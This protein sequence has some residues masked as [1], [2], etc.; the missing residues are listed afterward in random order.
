MSNKK[1]TI[2]AP[3][4]SIGQ[5]RLATWRD[6][7]RESVSLASCKKGSKGKHEKVEIVKDFLKDIKTIEQYFVYPGKIR[8][9]KLCNAVNKEEYVSFAHS[10]SEI[11]RQLV[12]DEYLNHPTSSPSEENEQPSEDIRELSS[13]QRKNY[14]EVLFVEDLSS[15]DE[16]ALHEKLIEIREPNEQFTYDFLVQPSFQDALIA[17]LFNPNLASRSYKICAPLCFGKYL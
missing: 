12:S 5:L 3:Y 11:N 9:E 13:G 4:Y 1:K 10:I 8:L 14:F 7:K 16:A 2:S 15:K 6:L 17:L